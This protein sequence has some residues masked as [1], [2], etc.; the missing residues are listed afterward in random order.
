MTDP[1]FSAHSVMF[2][3]RGEF[4]YG[5]GVVIFKGVFKV[6]RLERKLV[7]VIIKIIVMLNHPFI[8]TLYRILFQVPTVL[9]FN[10][11]VFNVGFD[12]YFWYPCRRLLEKK[13]IDL[14]V[15]HIILLLAAI[16]CGSVWEAVSYTHLRAHE[17]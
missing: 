13:G 16:A 14:K 4:L 2:Y 7:F 6:A 10:F 9:I 11:L 12:W 15:H 1:E 3:R 5:S 17:T 8:I